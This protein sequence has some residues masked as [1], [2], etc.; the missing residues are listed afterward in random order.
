MRVVLQLVCRVVKR[1]AM[2]LIG[3][4]GLRRHR[5]RSLGLCPIALHHGCFKMRVGRLN[6]Q[7]PDR[8]RHLTKV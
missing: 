6:G 4:A 3:V 8:R 2:L 5:S 7:V 1:G